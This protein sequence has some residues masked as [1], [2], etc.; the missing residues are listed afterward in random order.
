MQGVTAVGAVV[1]N[2]NWDYLKANLMDF[3]GFFFVKVGIKGARRF[4]CLDS[5]V[6]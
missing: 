4:F 2:R 5:D 1:L 6:Y 3:L